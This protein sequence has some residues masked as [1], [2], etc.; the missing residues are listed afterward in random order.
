M[1]FII[2]EFNK[3]ALQGVPLFTLKPEHSILK[4]RH[5]ISTKTAKFLE[6]EKFRDCFLC[7]NTPW[8]L[9]FVT[10][11]PEG[12]TQYQ[13]A[14]H[15]QMAVRNGS[16]ERQNIG[17]VNQFEGKKGDRQL[18]PKHLIRV[19]ARKMCLFSLYFVKYMMFITLHALW[20]DWGPFCIQ[21]C[22]EKV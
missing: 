6:F 8:A 10:Y 7:L 1:Q 22:I 21:I 16:G 19:V 5:K 13:I 2:C 18:Q 20:N 12:G 3:K 9:R 4:G 15:W 17:A 14:T 11:T